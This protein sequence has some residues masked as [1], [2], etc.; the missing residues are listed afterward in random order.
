LLL[1]WLG[2]HAVDSDS[3][4]TRKSKSARGQ[5]VRYGNLVDRNIHR[6]QSQNL[7][8]PANSRLMIWT[9][10]HVENFDQHDSAFF[11]PGWASTGQFLGA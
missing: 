6:L 1:D 3:R 4:G 2:V 8:E 5:V 11:P 10:G 7:P 9:T